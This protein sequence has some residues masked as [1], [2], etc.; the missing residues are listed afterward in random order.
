MG[1][2]V[3]S[4]DNL[5]RMSA[6][7]LAARLR[8]REITA[9]DVVAAH[10][11]RIREREPSIHAWTALDADRA[12]ERARELDRGPIAGPL[13]GLPI[14]VKDVIDTAALATERGSPIYRGRRPSAD[15]ACVAAALSAGAVMLGKSV[16]TEL[17]AFKPAETVNPRRFTHTPGGSSSGSAA[18]VAD[19]MVPL[20][21]GTQT[22]GSVIR[23][24]SY[25]GIVGYKPSFGTIPTDGVLRLAESLDTV[26]VFARSAE[27]AAL[28]AG[29][30][31]GR[32]DLVD[33]RPLRAPPR[34]GICRTYEWPEVDD[35]GRAALERTADALSRAGAQ[36]VRV[37]LPEPF[38]GLRAACEHIYG[39][40]LSRNLAEE[41][42][43]HAELL[44][45]G[46][47][48]S[49]DTGARVPPAQYA[50]AQRRASGWRA[51]CA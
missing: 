18:A 23:P 14:A 50:R 48:E 22:F 30:A 4:P 12:I 45:D 40:E 41:R 43:A 26:G 38:A 19:G 13:H 2:L 10:L 6:T 17:A 36:I 31:A 3:I 11:E 42:R 34:I 5:C 39:Y 33:I 7:A 15:A 35:A 49:I 46:L 44:S 8:R 20:A 27:D 32:P 51:A 28:L 24:A 29:A 16:T 47:R 1:H 9:S 25:C 21:F 37:E